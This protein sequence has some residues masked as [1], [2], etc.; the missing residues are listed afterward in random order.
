MTKTTDAPAVLV[1]GLEEITDRVVAAAAAA[2][3]QVRLARDAGE[4]ATGPDPELLFVGPDQVALVARSPVMGRANVHLV[5]MPGDKDR[6]CE[7]SAALGAAVIVLP[8]GV[9]WLANALSGGRGGVTATVLGLLGATG[10]V[11]TSTLTAG[12]GVLAA[13]R[14]HRV[15]LVDLDARGGG[16]DLLV[17]LEQQPGWRWPHLV[18]ADGFLGDLHDHL[19]RQGDLAVISHDRGEITDVPSPA[20]VAVLRSLSRSHDLVLLDL[21][22]RPGPT[23]LAG[24]RGADGGLLVCPGDVRGLVAATQQVRT[25][26]PHI[27]LAAVLSGLRPGGG[28]EAASR[29][30]GLPVVA[31]LPKDRGIAGEA[32]RGEVP[33]R[34]AGRAWRRCCA[35]ILDGTMGAHDD[36]R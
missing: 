8:D 4:L 3:T 10:G 13:E 15:A 1:T 5:G 32:D 24:L 9:R 7:W 18:D 12:L 11:G 35:T 26:D 28:R 20:V 23:E 34:L 30:L 33:G 22:A 16:L 19:P 29:A 27:P 2:G 25:I 17:G 14:G 31:T 21:G 6:L 36:G